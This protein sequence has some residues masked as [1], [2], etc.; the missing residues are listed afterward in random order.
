MIFKDKIIFCVILI[1]SIIFTIG[2]A[3]EISG[4]KYD[5]SAIITFISVIVGFLCTGFSILFNSS[6]IDSLYHI[7]DEENKSI[8]LKHRIK[9]YFL[10]ALRYSILSIIILLLYPEK[11]NFW[12]IDLLK[13]YLIIPIVISNSIL[14]LILINY[15]SKIFIKNKV[16]N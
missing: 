15:L 7:I 2:F 5:Y 3:R 9:N 11:V 8:S 12:G 16:K 1:I 6:F 10:F 13:Q 14:Y 4:Y